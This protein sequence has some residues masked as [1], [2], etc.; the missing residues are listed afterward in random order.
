MN[1]ILTRTALVAVFFMAL[2]TF[3]RPA[4]ADLNGDLILINMERNVLY[5]HLYLPN[6]IHQVD[7]EC[8]DDAIANILVVCQRILTYN[9]T[10]AAWDMYYDA[11]NMQ[12][13]ISGRSQ[14]TAIAYYLYFISDETDLKNGY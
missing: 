11:V 8:D 14:Q 6:P 10:G 7:W 9:T 13:S 5:S 4:H 2:L 12:D 1:K 3:C